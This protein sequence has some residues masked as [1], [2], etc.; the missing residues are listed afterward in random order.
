MFKVIVDEFSENVK[1]SI[2]FKKADARGLIFVGSLTSFS[3]RQ[4][5]DGYCG[6]V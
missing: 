1:S 4:T 5:I 3:Q 2:K 6:V